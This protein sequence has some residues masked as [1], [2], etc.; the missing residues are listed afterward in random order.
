M[1]I[2][3]TQ[4]M[5]VWMCIGFL[6]SI[7]LPS[8][9]FSCTSSGTKTTKTESSDSKP[10]EVVEPVKKFTIDNT[11]YTIITASDGCEYY[12]ANPNMGFNTC[13]IHYPKCRNR[14]GH[15]VN[16]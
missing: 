16:D 13:Y 15:V 10:L 1:K 11:I 14:I 3:K 8:S 7:L 6:S 5:I 12:D 4:T 9:L 2:P